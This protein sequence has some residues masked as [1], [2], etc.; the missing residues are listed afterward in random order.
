MNCPTCDNKD[1]KVIDSRAVFNTIRRRR[2]CLKCKERYT[3][4]EYIMGDPEFIAMKEVGQI[5]NIA[6]TQ[7]EEARNKSYA[8]AR[9]EIN[10]G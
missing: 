10:V 3:T 5:I 8:I 9:G 6:I 4:R 7:L 1:S 2:E